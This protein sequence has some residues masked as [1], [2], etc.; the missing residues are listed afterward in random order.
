M[1][2]LTQSDKYYSEKG[3]NKSIK[4][5]SFESALEVFFARE[6]P[7]LGG[8][9]VR[10]LIVKE[11][12]K[13]VEDYYPLTERMQMG[14]TMWVGVAKEEK[15][16][17]GKKL[18]DTKLRPVI[19][20][21]CNTDDMEA[22]FNK[23]NKREIKKEIVAR[24]YKKSFE[25]GACLTAVDISALTKLSTSTI[26]KYAREYEQENDCLLPR[27]GIIHD[28]GRSITHK[29][30]I[31]RKVILEGKT[32][33]DTARETNHSVEAVTRY[34]VNFK[35]IYKCLEKGLSVNDT[36]FA[37]KV[38]KNL[39]FEYVNLMAKLKEKHSDFNVDNIPF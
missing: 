2:K 39:V 3:G 19:L 22:L 33:E 21:I 11:V 37:I 8:K 35:R 38:S 9:L 24:L 25:Q 31:C 1:S 14:Q 27:R 10:P 5:K 32:V 23:K 29:A 12:K 13:I 30:I 16:S 6:F 15:Q 20:D 4:S 28:I 26:S 7:Q 34:I 18:E 17:Y 36:S